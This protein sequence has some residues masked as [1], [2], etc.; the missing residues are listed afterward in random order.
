MAAARW[1]HLMIDGPESLLPELGGPMPMLR[2]LDLNIFDMGN[3][4]STVTF[5]EVPQLR[6]VVLN[7]RVI[8]KVN[9]PWIQLTSLTLKFA[10]IS[11]CIRI[12]AQTI[13]L[14]QC[15][16][17]LINEAGLRLNSLTSLALLLPRLE[18]LA[19]NTY[20][21]HPPVEVFLH[22]FVVPSLC[23]LELDESLLGA[24]PISALESFISR[25]ACRLQDVC[26]TGNRKTHHE[27][28]LED[29]SVGG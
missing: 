7:R 27:S 11:Q 26:I 24:Q 20:L 6:T 2:S 9:L 16:L 23:R 21:Q 22:S 17:T 5:Y 3:D 15:D 18:S 4:A 29:L 1:E 19:L 13:N 25:S 8:S 12:L 10:G 14:V 28:F